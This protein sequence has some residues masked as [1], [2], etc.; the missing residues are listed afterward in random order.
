MARAVQLRD[1]FES[2]LHQVN[3]GAD[4]TD[5]VGDIHSAL[6]CDIA[7]LETSPY[8]RLAVQVRR[9]TRAEVRKRLGG[10]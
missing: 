7:F 1:T 8:D 2:L 6:L 5:A 10:I 9:Y 3:E 4:I